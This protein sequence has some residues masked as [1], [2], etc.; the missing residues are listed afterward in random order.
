MFVFF[1]LEGCASD[2]FSSRCASSSLPSLY[3]GSLFGSSSPLS[4]SVC[5]PAFRLTLIQSARLFR[6]SSIKKNSATLAFL[7][8][9]PNRTSG[10]Y[11]I[12]PSDLI[13]IS[14]LPFIFLQWLGYFNSAVNPFLYTFFNPE[15][16]MAF[17]IM[18]KSCRNQS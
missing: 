5:H 17:K 2:E 16:R 1:V 13:S 11:C 9:P 6:L 14:T 15:F 4:T 18:F 7:Y 12:F 10:P 3:A 8:L